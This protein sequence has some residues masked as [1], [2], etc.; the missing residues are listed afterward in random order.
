MISTLKKRN[1]WIII[2]LFIVLGSGFYLVLSNN[3]LTVNN[4]LWN[5]NS[6]VEYGINAS[7]LYGCAAAGVCNTPFI[8]EPL[9]NAP[10]TIRNDG[11]N[12]NGMFFHLSSSNSEIQQWS[13]LPSNDVL[14]NRENG[15]VES[16]NWANLSSSI[17]K[18]CCNLGT[19]NWSGT[20]FPVDNFH[21]GL[22]TNITFNFSVSS[23]LQYSGKKSYSVIGGPMNESVNINGNNINI[24][25]WKLAIPDFS[26]EINQSN[27]TKPLMFSSNQLIFSNIA[28]TISATTG[29]K[30]SSSFHFQFKVLNNNA[31]WLI[32]QNNQS[33]GINVIQNLNTTLLVDQSVI[34]R[35]NL[36]IL[37]SE[38]TKEIKT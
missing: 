36:S 27:A 38:V 29:L 3:S 21:V 34:S 32:Y 23:Y 24:L 14:V 37:L 33:S 26:I 12:T 11:M 10:I 35:P 28:I 18:F 4:N 31:W 19:G 7:I 25:A 9:I 22:K 17:D 13:D 2:F 16:N 8:P 20:F 5:T 6:K 1:I 15:F 30:L